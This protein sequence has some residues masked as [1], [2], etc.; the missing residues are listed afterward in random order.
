MGILLALKELTPKL[1]YLAMAIYLPLWVTSTG[2]RGIA[3]ICTD[4]VMNNI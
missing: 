2:H 1:V 3:K 4:G